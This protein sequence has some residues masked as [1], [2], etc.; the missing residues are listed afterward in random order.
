MKKLHP[1][2]KRYRSNEVKDFKNRLKDRKNTRIFDFLPDIVPLM[3]ASDLLIGD[4]SAVTR[5]FLAFKKPYIFL[6]NKQKWLWN[7]KKK[8]L[9]ECGETIANPAELWPAV[10]RALNNPSKYLQAIEK[11]FRY[12]F[13]KPDGR[14]ADRAAFEIK[15]YLDG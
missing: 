12:T 9:W 2:L 13:Y 8:K 7:R 5:E 10:Q 11:H 4:V 15:R 3:A 14:A 1:N 6:I